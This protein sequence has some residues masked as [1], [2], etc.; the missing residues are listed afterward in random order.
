VSSTDDPPKLLFFAFLA[1]A[2]PVK[3]SQRLMV[4]LDSILSCGTHAR[5]AVS[6]LH[7]R[8]DWMHHFANLQ[9]IM[10]LLRLDGLGRTRTEKAEAE[11]RRRDRSR[12]RGGK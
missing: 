2:T 1:P 7:K 8:M 10:V 6:E 4:W 5:D 3:M 11:T 12:S 9:R